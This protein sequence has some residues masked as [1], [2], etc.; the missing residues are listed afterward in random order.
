MNELYPLLF[1]TR[2]TTF[3]PFA[4]Q[5]PRN[6]HTYLTFIDSC[7]HALRKKQDDYQN[8]LMV[9]TYHLPNYQTQ[10]KERINRFIQQELLPIQIEIDCHIELIYCEYKDELYRRQLASIILNDEQVLLFRYFLR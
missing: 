2:T 6:V 10:F 5:Y 3:A 8:M 1:E 9:E 4:M 7:I